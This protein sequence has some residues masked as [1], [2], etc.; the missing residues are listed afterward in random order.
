MANNVDNRSLGDL[1]KEL[2]RETGTLV[3][4]EV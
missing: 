2:S 3:R 1:F 4:K